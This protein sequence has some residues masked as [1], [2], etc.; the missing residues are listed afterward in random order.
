MGGFD[1]QFSS[2]N[3]DSAAGFS[4]FPSEGESDT[5]KQTTSIPGMSNSLSRAVPGIHVVCT[6][7]QVSNA[8]SLIDFSFFGG[9][10]TSSSFF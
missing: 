10:T 1:L 2:E 5:T 3:N 4:F 9:D 6:L 7:D 8:Y